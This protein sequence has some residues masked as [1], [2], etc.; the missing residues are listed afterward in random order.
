MTLGYLLLV[1]VVFGVNLLPAFGPPTWA[2]LV[3]FR[4]HFRLEP[5]PLIVAGAL[6]AASGRYV[7]GRVSHRFGAR[8][9]AAR[10]A[11]LE[12]VRQ[13]VLRRHAGTVAGLGLFALSPVPSG[14]LF[15]GAGLVGAPMLPT[16][17]AFFAGRIVSYTGYV[18]AAT[19]LD[20]SYRDVA[21]ATFRS[22]VGI[23]VQVALLAAL[24]ALPLVDWSHR[25]RPEVTKDPGPDQPSPV[26]PTTQHAHS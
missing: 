9:S 12:A 11:R 22:P 23:A 4:F 24:A 16:T 13:R 21:L 5:V 10:R 25:T 6:A 7:L 26:P 1:A 20:H 14:Q 17:A 18:V 3:L 2:L 19:A 8:L 15:V